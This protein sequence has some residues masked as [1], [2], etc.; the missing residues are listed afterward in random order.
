MGG[1]YRKDAVADG[2]QDTSSSRRLS[3]SGAGHR[4]PQQA[5]EHPPPGAGR[6]SRQAAGLA[7][8]KSFETFK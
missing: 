7:I 5:P 3:G 1:R 6:G 8:L 2:G 4:R